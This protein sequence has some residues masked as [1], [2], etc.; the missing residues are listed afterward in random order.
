MFHGGCRDGAR[1]RDCPRAD[2][3]AGAVGGSVVGTVLK[4]YDLGTIGNLIIGIIGGGIGAQIIGALVGGGEASTIVGPDGFDFGTLIA[5]FAAG[6][7]GG[8]GLVGDHSI[9]QRKHG[10][11][12]TNVVGTSTQRLF[13]T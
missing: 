4:Q 2:L 7:F 12:K 1:S 5:Q 13:G 9:D 8:G 6:A 10:R 3:I 11:P